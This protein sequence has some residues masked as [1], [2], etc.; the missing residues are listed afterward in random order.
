MIT[1]KD[2]GTLHQDACNIR[3]AIHNIFVSIVANIDSP[4]LWFVGQSASPHC[5]F[6]RQTTGQWSS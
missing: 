2:F 1:G 6:I 4:A 5:I 3:T